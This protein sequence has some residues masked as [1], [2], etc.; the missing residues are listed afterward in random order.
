MCQFK[1]DESRLESGVELGH[2]YTEWGGAL[3]IGFSFSGISG[4]KHP[5]FLPQSILAA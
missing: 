1:R 4:T 3:R 5:A 2:Y